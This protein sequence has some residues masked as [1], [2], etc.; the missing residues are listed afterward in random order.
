MALIRETGRSELAERYIQEEIVA[1]L[2]PGDRIPSERELARELGLALPTVNKILVSL[3]DRGVL[4]RKRGIGTFVAE[5]S[6]AGKVVRILTPSPGSYHPETDLFWYNSQ[7][8]LEGMLREAR[9]LGMIVEPYFLDFHRQPPTA[10]RLAGLLAPG[11]AGFAM[12]FPP[13]PDGGNDWVEE[14][15][16]RRKALVFR[17]FRPVENCS[18]VW[19]NLRE[20]VCEAVS[21]LLERGRRRIA[22]FESFDAND[23]YVQSRLQGVHDAF[24]RFGIEPAPELMRPT[25][26]LRNAG[27]EA[28]KQLLR[29]GIAFDAVFGGYDLSTFGIMRAL[30][31]AGVRIPEDAAVIGSDDLPQCGEQDPPLATVRYP[32]FDMGGGMC[33]ILADAIRD[34]A[35][36]PVH[37]E[38]KCEWIPR[39]SAG[40]ATG[41]I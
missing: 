3:T 17:S 12:H 23:G 34:P 31:E 37:R 27:Y 20:G 21:F 41:S 8:I 35:A 18:T 26:L 32:M 25:P 6:P 22:V 10:E 13:R 5:V 1:K 2:A 19:G 40:T 28:M 16:S 11:V 39:A 24:A 14:L 15:R 36:P 4:A 7:F 9:R 33:R 38:F 29:E 30:H